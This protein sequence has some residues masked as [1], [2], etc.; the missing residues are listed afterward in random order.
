MRLPASLLSAVALQLPQGKLEVASSVV[1][2]L[3][4]LGNYASETSSATPYSKFSTLASGAGVT[5][6]TGMLIIYAPSLIL[7]GW[8]IRAA[9]LSSSRDLL[10]KG[11]LLVHF[12]KRVLETLFVHKY[13]GSV[14]LATSSFI[15]VYYSL[16]SALLA[17]LHC[18]QPSDPAALLGVGLFVVGQL[19][20]LYHHVLLSNLRG[21]KAP[22]G[23]RKS[24]YVVPRGGFF[25]YVAMPHYF[26]E[27]VAWLGVAV[28]TQHLTALLVVTSMASYLAGRSVSTTK[29]YLKNVKGYPTTRRH[30][31]PGIF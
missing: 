10:V 30:L 29:Y 23:D 17:S 13:S 27:L 11:L 21:P 4:T 24:A 12:L 1:F 26:F 31:V 19:G 22:S 16:V 7:L 25:E 14:S 3:L 18:N 6:R 8:L 5:G 20:N 2:G 15:G 28:C 9:H